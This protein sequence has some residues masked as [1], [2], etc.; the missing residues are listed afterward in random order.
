[1]GSVFV[2]GEILTLNA[3]DELAEALLTVGDEIY[4]V[5]DREDALSLADADTEVVDLGGRALL[6][7]SA[8]RLFPEVARRTDDWREVPRL[9]RRLGG[10]CLEWGA[11]AELVVLSGRVIGCQPQ[12]LSGLVPS[13]GETR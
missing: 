12:M 13:R 4:F 3:C 6:S 10:A 11:P 5:G 1:M 8:Y 2:N 9:L 7:L